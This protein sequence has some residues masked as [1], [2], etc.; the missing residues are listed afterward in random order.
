MKKFAIESST[1]AANQKHQC[2]VAKPTVQ[3][4]VRGLGKRRLAVNNK[5]HL[6]DL[7]PQTQTYFRS[8]LLSLSTSFIRQ[9]ITGT[10]VMI[11]L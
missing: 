9:E 1:S 2:E 8:S 6:S 4:T 3:A 11:L 10:F 7:S 5:D